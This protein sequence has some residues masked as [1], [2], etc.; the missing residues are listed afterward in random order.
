M[1][2]RHSGHSR[3]VAMTQ[4]EQSGRQPEAYRPY[5]EL[6]GTQS[7]MTVHQP[8]TYDKDELLTRN[9]RRPKKL[10]RPDTPRIDLYPHPV[11]ARRGLHQF[12]PP[13]HPR[14]LACHL[15]DIP[16]SRH[17]HLRIALP[18]AV[19]VRAASARHRLAR[20]LDAPARPWRVRTTPTMQP[21]HFSSTCWKST[22]T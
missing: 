10:P 12:F 5:Q 6:T 3:L 13:V 11:S 8:M 4:S 17:F 22:F 16:A 19:V 9:P 20:T 18:R 7:Q 1:R 15:L 2:V 21:A 14:S